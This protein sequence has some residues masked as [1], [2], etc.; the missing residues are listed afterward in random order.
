VRLDG[1]LVAE[2]QAAVQALPRDREELRGP[3]ND[4]PSADRRPTEIGVELA[5]RV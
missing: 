5:Q 4:E 2:L 3:L 1:A